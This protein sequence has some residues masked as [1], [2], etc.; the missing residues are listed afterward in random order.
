MVTLLDETCKRYLPGTQT[1]DDDATRAIWEAA[2][3][4][5]DEC[6]SFLLLLLAKCAAEDIDGDARKAMREL[7]LADDM[8]V[9]ITADGTR[10]KYE[11]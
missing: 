5:F 6:L 2:P 4:N 8:S 1:P 9:I 10:L 11:V 3:E 7:L